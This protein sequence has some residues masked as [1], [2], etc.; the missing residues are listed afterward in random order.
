M[1][2]ARRDSATLVKLLSID[3]EVPENV[4]YTVAAP[5]HFRSFAP[6]DVAV[7]LHDPNHALTGPCPMRVHI[8]DAEDERNYVNEHGGDVHPN[9]T[10]I[11]SINVEELSMDRDYKLVVTALSGVKFR[12]ESPL[13]LLSKTH[14]ILIQTDK[15][16]YKPSELVRFRVLV[17]DKQLKAATLP[18]D[19]LS[20][21]IEVSVKFVSTITPLIFYIC[22]C[23]ISVAFV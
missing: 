10:E 22:C 8:E 11:I 14:A 17:L 3:T 16:K 12:H 19:K 4:Y 5:S 9:T 7:T 6:F 15:P 20:I 1:V 21:Y 18:W 23:Y 2:R 13:N